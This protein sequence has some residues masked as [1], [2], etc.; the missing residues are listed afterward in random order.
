M[1]SIAVYGYSLDSKHSCRAGRG[2]TTDES[3]MVPCLRHSAI[4]RRYVYVPLRSALNAWSTLRSGRCLTS[5]LRSTSVVAGR[6]VYT[7][8][9]SLLDACHRHAATLALSNAGTQRRAL[10]FAYGAT[11]THTVLSANVRASG[12]A[13][14]PGCA[15]ACRAF[16]VIY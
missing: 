4:C 11:R 8:F 2:S 7:P 6:V 5:G 10:R 1:E 12:Q 3:Q 15:S 14:L 16:I 13:S 9:R